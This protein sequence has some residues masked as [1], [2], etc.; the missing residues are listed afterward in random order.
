MS[1]DYSFKCT[2]VNDKKQKNIHTLTTNTCVCC[3]K[4]KQQ[5]FRFLLESSF[6]KKGTTKN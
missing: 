5:H 2:W 1:N 6:Q 3:F 4:Q